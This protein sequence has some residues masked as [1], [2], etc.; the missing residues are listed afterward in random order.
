ME[1]IQYNRIQEVLDEKKKNVYWLQTQLDGETI[2]RIVRWCKNVK[3]PT[4]EELFKIAKILDVDVREL[5]VST[6]LQ[7]NRENYDEELK[8]EMGNQA[9]KTRKKEEYIK[10]CYNKIDTLTAVC[11]SKDNWRNDEYQELEIGKSYRVTH[12]SVM[13]SSSKIMLEDFGDKEF[14]TVCFDLYENGKPLYN[15][16]TR[17][18]R[19][20]APYLRERYN[21]PRGNIN[22]VTEQKDITSD[23]ISNETKGKN[24]VLNHFQGKDNVRHIFSVN[25]SECW[26]TQERSFGDEV[27]A[28]GASKLNTVET[29]TKHV[30]FLFNSDDEEVGRYYLGKK[31]RGKTPAK[32]VE[33]K[34]DICFFESWNPEQ[35]K[36]VPCVGFLSMSEGTTLYKKGCGLTTILNENK[37]YVVDENDNYVVPP[38][39]YDYIDG[40]DKCGLARVKLNGK[41]DISNP[42][43]FTR[44]RWG[45]IDTEGNE[46]IPVIYTEIWSFYNKNRETTKVWKGDTVAFMIDGIIQEE[47]QEKVYRYDFNLYTHDLI[48]KEDW[49]E[50]NYNRLDPDYNW[51]PSDDYSIWD[52]LD[53]EPEAAGNI[54][55]EW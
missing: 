10:N 45:I 54:D 1:K 17:D 36:W 30:L 4:I 48:L 29:E 5:I 33:I 20:W 41:T 7:P 28:L 13:R 39:R 53:G 12:I 40:F 55:Y 47:Y 18:N 27:Y 2:P 25:G 35:K 26:L 43:H 14:N 22:T 46:I 51:D 8:S 11:R 23:G 38:G 3:Q 24:E 9:Q 19:F 15:T 44:D 32:I 49:R 34:H 31:L 21:M 37:W 6:K 42:G 50:G 16:F 52:A